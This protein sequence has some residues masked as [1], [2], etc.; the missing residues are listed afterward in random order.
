MEQAPALTFI[1]INNASAGTKEITCLLLSER[2]HLYSAQPLCAHWAVGGKGSSGEV[3]SNLVLLFAKLA[4][5]GSGRGYEGCLRFGGCKGSKACCMERCPQMM[6]SLAQVSPQ[7][8]F[9]CSTLCFSPCLQLGPYLKQG[10]KRL[11]SSFKA[12]RAQCP[13]RASSDLSSASPEMGYDISVSL[14]GDRCDRCVCNVS[15]V[16]LVS[17]AGMP[18]CLRSCAE[19][20]QSPA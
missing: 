18:G 16:C 3:G 9:P 2:V 11:C 20:C 15:S 12:K 17:A 10:R 8:P 6:L 19:V 1:T 14:Q 13:Q 7:H 5:R 4:V